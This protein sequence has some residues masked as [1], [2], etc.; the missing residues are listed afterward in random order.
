MCNLIYRAYEPKFLWALLFILTITYAYALEATWLTF[1]AYGL[2]FVF[3][4]AMTTSYHIE[5]K[6]NELARAIKF[7]GFIT[8][9][10]TIRAEQIEKLEVIEVG[11]KTIILLYVEKKMRIKLQR[12]SPK[13]FPQQ[14]LEFAQT[15]NIN[16]IREG[17]V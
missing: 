6:E 2:S 10:K 17:K 7:F 8:F 1:V 3:F 16:V 12:Y 11:E 4:A 14:L 15:N 9:N 5:I 13:D